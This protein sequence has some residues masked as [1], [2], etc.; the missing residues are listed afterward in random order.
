MI[1]LEYQARS[2]LNAL[3]Q[4]PDVHLHNIDVPNRRAALVRL[5]RQRYIDAAFL[6]DR[7]LTA[8]DTAVWLPLEKLIEACG[9][10]EAQPHDAIF[11]IAHCGSTLISR[12]IGA[13][14]NN[15]PK[16]EPLSWL[17]C[18]I[19]ARQVEHTI[20]QRAFLAMFEATSRLLARRYAPNERVI[21]KSTSVAASLLPN[22]LSREASQRAVLLTMPAEDWIATMLSPHASRT[23]ID[24][25]APYWAFD[26]G[27]TPEI[28]GDP[29]SS[30]ELAHH[31]GAAWVAPMLWFAAAQKNDAERVKL[32]VTAD[33]LESPAVGLASLSGFLG[34]GADSA[35]IETAVN[36]PILGQYSKDVELPYDATL[37]R[38]RLEAS[39]RDNAEQIAVAMKFVERFAANEPLIADHLTG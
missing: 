15:L 18:G 32:C 10:I 17:S 5:D 36:G 21:V 35:A 11:H 25:V 6:D 34:L 31:I 33:L 24:S 8:N 26:L 20:T 28:T 7:A 14:P 29:I 1:D 30:P 19:A 2:L 23:S 12:L 3:P 9:R 4:D 37:R 22:F 13:L 38:S 16:R 39:K 27:G